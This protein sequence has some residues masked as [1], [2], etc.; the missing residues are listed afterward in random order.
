M[1]IERLK[2]EIETLRGII[3]DEAHPAVQELLEECLEGKMFHLERLV[4]EGG[5]DEQ[6]DD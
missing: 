4:E 1:T 6:S 3:A 5:Q 2:S